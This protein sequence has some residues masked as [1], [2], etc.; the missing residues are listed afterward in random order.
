MEVV[1]IEGVPIVR[2]GTYQLSTGERTFAEEDL[3]AAADALANDP[4]VKA[5]RIKIDSVER[6]LG[7]DPMAH[8]GEPAFGWADN[9]RVSANGQ[10]LLAD[11]HV[12]QAVRDAMEW[13]YPSLSIE[14]TPPGWTSATGQSHELVISAIA[15][16]GT[17]WPG[18]STLEDF[19]E[20]LA[21][22]PKIE[23]TADAEESVLATVPQRRN[24]A[25]SLDQ[26]LV[27]RRFYDGLESGD[28]ERPEGVESIRDLWVRSMRFDDTGSPYLKVTDEGSGRLFRVDFTVSGSDVTFGAFQEVVEQDVPVAAG[29]PRPLAPVAVWASREES[30][31]VA[32]Q[33]QEAHPMT[34]EQ[35]R[36]LAASFGLNPDEATE[37]DVMAAASAAAEARAGNPLETPENPETPATPATAEPE[38]VA[39]RALPPGATVIDSEELARLRAGAETAQTLAREQDERERDAVLA[40]AM[41]EGRFAP[42]RSEHWLRAWQADPEG[43]R[44]LLTANESEGGLAPNTIPVRARGAAPADE[45]G[46]ANFDA[47]HD[48]FMARHFPQSRR[49]QPQEA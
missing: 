9:L 42:S 13:A 4:A 11:F 1:T 48:A 39:A 31:A 14:G 30:R 17:H 8:G 45:S 22:G 3:C 2:V 44:H 5:P 29:A 19:T 20:F 26:D 7:L 15:L 24:V 18:V 21:E 25:A 16:L 27:V 36:A 40:Q 47:Q 46:E 6:A 41:R 34:D 32:I 12:P 37:A 38:P 10:E 49:R 23:I 43:T 33:H 28:V 35:R